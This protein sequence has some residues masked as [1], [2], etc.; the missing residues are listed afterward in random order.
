MAKNGWG[1]PAAW[2]SSRIL[3]E[4]SPAA[5][6]VRALIAYLA[7]RENMFKINLP[8]YPLIMAKALQPVKPGSCYREHTE[9]TSKPP[10]IGGSNSKIIL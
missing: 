3:S 8:L 5:S 6:S 1:I 4:R 7:V 10:G 2:A 9:P